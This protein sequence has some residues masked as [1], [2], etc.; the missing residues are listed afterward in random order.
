MTLGTTQTTPNT[1]NQN[2]HNNTFV[3]GNTI[4]LEVANISYTDGEGDETIAFD[5]FTT[6]QI[7][8]I[9]DPDVALDYYIGLTGATTVSGNPTFNASLASNGT[10]PS[11]FFTAADSERV[12]VRNLDFQFETVPIGVPEPSS[13]AYAAVLGLAGLRRR[14]RK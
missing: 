12:R 8:N 3:M 1:G 2:F 11:L 7:R 4:S 13:L 9:D 6:F 10:S 14:R 5:G